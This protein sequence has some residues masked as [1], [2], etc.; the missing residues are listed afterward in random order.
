[1]KTKLEKI[2]ERV[3]PW[4]R[5]TAEEHKAELLELGREITERA[6]QVGQGLENV[7]YEL[8]CIEK[9]F[10]A[11]EHRPLLGS[12]KPDLGT[13]NDFHFSESSGLRDWST[14]GSV[15]CLT[16]DMRR[17][18]QLTREYWKAKYAERK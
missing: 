15:V 7:R 5:K 12:Y 13:I 4:K 1:M 16:E 17:Y 14:L 18:H 3:W 9:D 8:G 10:D 2:V 11:Y 6:K